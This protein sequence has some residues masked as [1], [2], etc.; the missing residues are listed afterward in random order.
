MTSNAL[1][2][3]DGTSEVE[4][5]CCCPICLRT[6][7]EMRMTTK[8][9]PKECIDSGTSH[10]DFVYS[11]T[12]GHMFCLS[13]I[14][15]ILLAS[16]Y[17]KR[18]RTMN[19]LP[20]DEPIITTTQGACPM[21]RAEL[22]YF[23][24]RKVSIQNVC[25]SES[26]TNDV[27]KKSTS[28]I[29]SK[30]PVVVSSDPIPT[31]LLGTKFLSKDDSYVQFPSTM[32]EITTEG[33]IFYTSYFKEFVPT[34]L[35][36]LTECTFLA[37]TNTF[38][39]HTKTI[40]TIPGTKFTVWLNFSDNFQFITHGICRKVE[41]RKS[42]EDIIGGSDDVQPRTEMQTFVYPIS[43]TESTLM[44]RVNPPKIPLRVPYSSDTFWGNIFCQEYM[45]GLASYHF[46]K[47]P[48]SDGKDDGAIA[49]IC[50]DHKMTCAWP[51]LDNGRP[52]P[53]RVF[54]RN[55]SSPDPY[56]FRGS[57]CWYD[58]YQTT[59]NGCSRWDYEMKFDTKFACILSGTV[60]SISMNHD[61]ENSS[62]TEV[63]SKMSTFGVDLNY[64]NPGVSDSMVDD[65][66]RTFEFS[67]LSLQR[68]RMGSALVELKEQLE[69]QGVTEATLSELLDAVHHAQQNTFTT[70]LDYHQLDPSEQ[71]G[72]I[73]FDSEP[74]D[75][76]YY[77]E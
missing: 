72:V 55:I 54:F 17:T 18:T 39:A 38:K 49:Y 42:C 34:G 64:I 70:L 62:E 47:K 40:N 23:D 37:L 35:L 13:C 19:Y 68:A 22:S 41:R 66:L 4:N 61:N 5:E 53:S 10:T 74:F 51:P 3:Q 76:E 58:D 60:H 57:I 1:I 26:E 8:A 33:V 73:N 52:I 32:N 24:L 44:C 7:T 14:Q 43:V 2:P 71:V 75:L 67:E 59:W 45:V 11:R 56:T 12:C 46:V 63:I 28:I 30:D 48:D 6:S 50:Y 65:I 36:E 29:K 27:T 21:C 20:E 31:Q 15:Q 69:T 77:F 9:D 25:E 16:S